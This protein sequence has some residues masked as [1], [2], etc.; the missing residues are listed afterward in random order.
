MESFI[1]FDKGSGPAIW[2]R[3]F[4]IR[5]ANIESLMQRAAEESSGD[6]E[7]GDLKVMLGSKAESKPNQGR[8]NDWRGD[9]IIVARLLEIAVADQSNFPFVNCPIG[10]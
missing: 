6:I 7:D 9:V 4:A 8:M 3:P 1:Q 5:E 10:H 2:I